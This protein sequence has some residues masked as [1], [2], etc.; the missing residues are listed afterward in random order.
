MKTSRRHHRSRARR[1]PQERAQP[2]CE[3][4]LHACEVAAARIKSAGEE[5]AAS[6]TALCRDLPGG[7][8]CT[9]L[10]RR[11]AWCNVIELRLKEQ[12][13][14]LEEARQAV[15]AVWD[16]VML[17]ARGRELFSRFIKPES[18][19]AFQSDAHLP[20]LVRAASA[21]AA[22]RGGNPRLKK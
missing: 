17:A 20:L 12:E 2:D 19:P 3:Q 11:R 6:W 10:L 15:D 1:E 8:S 18:G 16:Q 4:A 14:A 9:D 21:L 22:A 13:H 5:L 7:A